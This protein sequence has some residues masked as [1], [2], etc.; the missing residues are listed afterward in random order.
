[1]DLRANAGEGT[2]K[3]QY[4]FVFRYQFGLQR[5]LH[6]WEVVRWH[7]IVRECA[8]S[9]IKKKA[10]FVDILKDLDL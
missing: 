4:I 7:L 2:R 5:A 1:M 6:S 3:S 9:D 8:N 10:N